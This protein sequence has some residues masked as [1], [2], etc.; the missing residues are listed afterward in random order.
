MITQQIF[1][2]DTWVVFDLNLS[3]Y[4]FTQI[5]VK[6]KSCVKMLDLI[7]TCIW[8]KFLY[9]NMSQI[10]VILWNSMIWNW[11]YFDWKFCTQIRVKY[12]SSLKIVWCEIDLYLTHIWVGK[13]SK[14]FW[15]KKKY[16]FWAN[17]S[18]LSISLSCLRCSI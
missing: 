9:S 16:C 6:I 3:T 17:C 1:E 7:L 4:F 14:F 15:K 18:I 11:L 5:W 13:L 10:Q 8:M 12:Q 2:N